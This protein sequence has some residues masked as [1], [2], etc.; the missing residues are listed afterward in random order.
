MFSTKTWL[1]II[2]AIAAN[3]GIFGTGA[4]IVLSVP[5]LAV[6]A[7]WLIPA[8]V[9]VSLVLA[10]LVGLWV[11]PRMRIRDWGRENWREGDAIS[12]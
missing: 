10:P 8:V 3:A 1:V 4:I 6:N 9:A 2:A 12:G 7:K 5:A 11:A